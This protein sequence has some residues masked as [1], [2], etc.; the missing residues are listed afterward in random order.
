MWMVKVIVGPK[1]TGKTKVL[2]DSAN[3][4]VQSSSEDVV[5]I[6]SDSRR[7]CDL[8][9]KIRFINMSDFPVDINRSCIFLGFICGIISENYDIGGILINHLPL[10]IAK[11]SQAV[12]ELFDGIKKLSEKF[13]IDIYLSIQG[14]PDSLPQLIKEYA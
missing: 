5:F 10:S 11:D 9:H 1:G 3:S 14:E 4:L 13:E 2:I 6:D 7:I 8:N 12:E